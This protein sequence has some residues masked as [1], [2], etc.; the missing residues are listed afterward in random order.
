M[1]KTTKIDRE[2]IEHAASL[3]MRVKDRYIIFI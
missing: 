2:K 1:F 3:Y